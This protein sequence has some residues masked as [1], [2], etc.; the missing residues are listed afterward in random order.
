[1]STRTNIKFIVEGNYKE[2]GKI[3]NYSEKRLV[4]QHSDGYPDTE[5]GVINQMKEFVK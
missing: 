5:C 2:K 1:M 3:E 4:Y